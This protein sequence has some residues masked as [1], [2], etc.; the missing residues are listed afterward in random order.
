MPDS[1]NRR[2][3]ASG[4]TGVLKKLP[5]THCTPLTLSATRWSVANDC[6]PF[7]HHWPAGW[8][9][10]GNAQLR[11]L[12]TKMKRTILMISGALALA[13]MAKAQTIT[14]YD[15]H[16]RFSDGTNMHSNSTVVTRDYTAERREAR[17]AAQA[18]R[19]EARQQAIEMRAAAEERARAEAEAKQ[20][21]YEACKAQDLNNQ[22]RDEA[23][24]SWSVQSR[25]SVS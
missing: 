16:T 4:N 10:A 7:S 24:A 9:L 17:E 8:A 3:A 2:I 1:G 15:D 6:H 25:S 18:A 5:L 22:M 21:F 13:T 20:R 19:E 14:E 23:L 11:F 12:K